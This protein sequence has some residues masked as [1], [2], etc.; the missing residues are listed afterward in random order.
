MQVS[1]LTDSLQRKPEQPPSHVS[2]RH[3]EQ[4]IAQQHGEHRQQ[5]EP[6]DAQN[7]GGSGCASR[8]QRDGCRN[9]HSYGFGEDDEK[10]QQVSVMSD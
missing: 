3:E 7:T 10:Y 2:S 8:H 4:G 9:G 5:Q 6:G 1:G